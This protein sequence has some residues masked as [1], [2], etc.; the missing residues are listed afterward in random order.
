MT[1]GRKKSIEIITALALR[2]R[3]NET[4]QEEEET[5]T[6]FQMPKST[7]NTT[8][9]KMEEK[10]DDMLTIHNKKWKEY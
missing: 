7:E 5:D 1:Q 10:I 6:E 8:I 3:Y 9:K 4:R 2:V